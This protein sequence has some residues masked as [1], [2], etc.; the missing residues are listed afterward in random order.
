MQSRFAPSIAAAFVS[1]AAAFAVLSPV[2][3]ATADPAKRQADFDNKTVLLRS[4]C[5]PSKV[6]TLA[7]T[8]DFSGDISLAPADGSELQLFRMQPAGGNIQIVSVPS[9]MMITAEQ[10]SEGSAVRL[11]NGIGVESANWRA[12][13]V[14]NGLFEFSPLLGN[15]VRLATGTPFNLAR[16][17]G[18]CTQRYSVDVLTDISPDTTLSTV[19]ATTTSTTPPPSTTPA[20]TTAV[21]T[22]SPPLPTNPG[23][24]WVR[25]EGNLITTPVST[26]LDRARAAKAAGANTVMFADPKIN[27]WFANTNLAAQWLP[28]MKELVAGVRAEGMKIVLQTVPVGYCTPFLFNDPNMTTGYPVVNAPLTVQS[29]RLVPDQ[30]ASLANG[31]FETYS[32]NVPAGWDVDSPG[33]ASFVDSSVAKSGS[34]SMRFEAASAPNNQARAFATA[35]VKPR[36]QYTL[37]FWAKTANL[38]A[39]YLGPYVIDAATGQ[40]LT[41]Q[42]YSYRNGPSRQYRGFT[43]S[44]S[45]DWTEMVIAFNSLDASS[46]RLALGAW[47]GTGTL[48]VDDVRI[49][50]TPLLNVIRRDN[51]P[52]TVRAPDGRAISEGSDITTIVDPELGQIEYTGNFDTYHASPTITLGP[53]TT[54]KEGDRVFFSGY[55][56][57]V[58]TAGQVGCSWHDPKVIALMKEVHRQ[59]ADN[60]GADGYLIDVEEVRTGGWEPTDA[61][62]ASSAA[63]LSAH[64]QQVINDASAVTGKPIYIWSD[65]FDPAA[66]AVQSFYQVKGSMVGSGDGLDPNAVTIITWKDGDEA[67]AAKEAVTYFAGRGFTQIIGG[68]YDRDVATNFNN[69]RPALA[70]QRNI[71]GSMYTTFTDDYS[72]LTEFGQLWWK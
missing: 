69:W 29:G 20:P 71:A 67:T 63:S 47:G 59:A 39:G 5:D 42:H 28:K 57:L 49:D 2:G 9:G 34:V 66:N 35:T 45:T 60:I 68:F 15:R 7:R 52:M 32:G 40:R 64:T 16:R 21:P 33:L 51:L 25:I 19:L 53:A 65:M 12:R 48:W 72:K 55:H 22:T 61:A 8:Y 6:V 44:L 36:Q 26:L 43:N 1:A 54:L 27:L 37:R 58:T 18:T 38:S 14:G 17:D 46:V 30:S 70:G 31:S 4:A 11:Q 13:P 62:Y 3:R 24:R 10:L 23:Q 50:T 41:D 56:A